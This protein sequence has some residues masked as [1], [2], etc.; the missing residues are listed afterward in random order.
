[1]KGRVI[2]P[3]VQ[4]VRSRRKIS[5][6]LPSGEIKRKGRL[7]TK[8][9][10]RNYEEKLSAEI[11]MRNYQQVYYRSENLRIIVI[12]TYPKRYFSKTFFF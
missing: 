8:I 9:L 4:G 10:T 3:P 11:M 1:M 7:I 12:L 6:N 5:G 2:E